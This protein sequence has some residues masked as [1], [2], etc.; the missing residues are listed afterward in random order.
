[1]IKIKHPALRRIKA[2]TRPMVVEMLHRLFDFLLNALI[3]RLKV[4][5]VMFKYDILPLWNIHH[6]PAPRKGIVFLQSDPSRSPIHARWP[7]FL[8]VCLCARLQ[9]RPRACPCVRLQARPRVFPSQSFDPHR[10][11]ILLRGHSEGI[12][13]PS[14]FHLAW[15][16]HGGDTALCNFISCGDIAQIRFMHQK[17]LQP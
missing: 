17:A 14:G 16:S 4:E 3:L 5:W 2:I 9:V 7:L 11:P 1:M 12:R 13:P 15:S 6:L 10:F 8:Q